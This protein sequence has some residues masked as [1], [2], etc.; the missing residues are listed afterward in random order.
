MFNITCI[1]TKAVLKNNIYKAIEKIDDNSFLEA[2]YK[3]I[4]TK[5]E[6]E[7]EH[8]LSDIQKKSLDDRKKRHQTGESKSSSWADVKKKA[9]KSLN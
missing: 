8:K 3:I 1:M 9:R 6:S 7:D 5:I 4:S 2:V